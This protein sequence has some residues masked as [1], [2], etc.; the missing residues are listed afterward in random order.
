MNVRLGNTTTSRGY[1]ME[2]RAGTSGS[3]RR[4]ASKDYH[5]AEGSRLR[6]LAPKTLKREAE[7]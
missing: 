3:F 6:F 7:A 2:A 5:Q 4:Q 1:Q